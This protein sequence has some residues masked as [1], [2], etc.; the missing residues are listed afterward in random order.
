LKEI[1]N[2]LPGDFPAAVFVVVHLSPDFPSTLD[3]QISRWGQLPAVQVTDGD[4]IRPGHIYTAP[5]DYHM[6]I[7]QGRIRVLRGPR[8]NRHRPAIDPLFR[9]AAREYG[10]R[11]VGI[12]LSGMNDDGAAGLY[13][14]KQLGGIAIVQDPGDAEWGE[15]PERALEY[16]SPQYIL[17]TRDIAPTLVKLVNSPL[18]EA[19]MA[20]EH[21]GRKSHK[22][23]GKKSVGRN[24]SESDAD[25]NMEVVYSDEGVGTPSVFACPE[26]HGVLWELK[27]NKLT[28]YRCRVGH[29]YTSDSLTLELSHASESALWAAVRALEEKAAMQR[30][31]ADGITGGY[32]VTRR[33]R[34]Q[35]VA[36]DA[37]ARLIRD[38]IFQRDAE[39][40][41]E[42]DSRKAR[43][44]AA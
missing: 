37:N 3:Q 21:S 28:R 42:E 17:H 30:R 27:N 8:E 39:L 5:P 2:N 26:C 38:M 35:A 10:P 25:R 7:E 18:D 44:K 43:Q 1:V 41:K 40:G 29:S 6:M 31:V 12:I 15:M 4:S 36:D 11:V 24:G 14:V 34:D 13:T 33:L 22:H 16:A 23:T 32:G 20:K 9:T 19:A